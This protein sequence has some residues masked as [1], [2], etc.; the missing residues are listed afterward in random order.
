VAGVTGKMFPNSREL[1]IEALDFYP[2]KSVARDDV[3]D[4]LVALVVVCA[5]DEALQTLPASLLVSSRVWG[6]A[7][8]QSC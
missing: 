1:V 5:S 4:A 8:P 3:L 2:R 6:Q 7:S